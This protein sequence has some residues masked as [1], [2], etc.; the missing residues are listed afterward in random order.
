MHT[1]VLATQKGGSGK[2]T[3]AISLALAAKKAGHNVRLIDA[4]PQGT[5]S[6]WR[7]R[8]VDAE[9]IVETIDTV[10][11][12]EPRLRALRDSGVTLTIID[13]AGGVSSARTAAIRHADLCLIPARPTTA[14]IEATAS[15]LSLVR[16]W[17]KPF[18]FVLNQVPSRGRR[19]DDAAETLA[20]E[21]AI[22]LI[23]VLARP[24]IVMRNDHQDALSAGLA[25]SEYAPTSKST[26]EI[27]RL[28][29]WIEARL[30]VDASAGV[31][32]TSPFAGLHLPIRA[33]QP[34]FI[35]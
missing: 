4:D 12:I 26:E 24:F 13:A 8:R 9:P 6:N 19:I 16:A 35:L 17:S 3:L 34:A 11:D 33:E 23:E 10:Q 2:S 32:A 7:K 22:D 28:W 27:R 20:D 31:V 15:T 30:G 25:V 29:N 18:A 1:I 5:L 21:A 14:D